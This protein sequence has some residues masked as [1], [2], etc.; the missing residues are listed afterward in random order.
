MSHRDF[1]RRDGQWGGNPVPVPRDLQAFDAAQFASLNGDDGGAWNPSSPIVV[2]GS[3]VILSGGTPHLITGGVSTRRGGRIELHASAWPV[4]TGHSRTLKAPI[5]GAHTANGNV[6]QIDVSLDPVGTKFTTVHNSSPIQWTVPQRF[7]HHGTNI[8]GVSL[9]FRVG[10][11]HSGVPANLPS[12][13]LYR[14]HQGRGTFDTIASGTLAA[15]GS[16][17]AYYASG[18]AQTIA[19]SI[20]GSADVDVGLYTYMLLI[21]DEFG[22]NSIAGNV[23]TSLNLVYGSIADLRPE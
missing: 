9:K 13:T 17:T 20:S 8:T 2:G 1:V 15:P 11:P 14:G 18:N 19:G 6:D 5:V 16:G 22:T 23:Y 7:L 4:C 12:F 3:G 10:T 21:T